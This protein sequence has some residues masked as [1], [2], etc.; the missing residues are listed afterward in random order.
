M[1]NTIDFAVAYFGVLRAG[2][3]AVPLNPAYTEDERGYALSDSGVSLLVDGPLP[4]GP[5]AA[6]PGGVAPEDVAV[7]LYTS[8]T[9]RASEGR[10]ADPRGAGRQPRQLDAIQPP[11]VAPDDVVLLAMPFFHAYGL[12]TGLGMVAHHAATGVLATGRAGGES[13]IAE[14]GV[15]VAVGVPRCTPPG[16]GSRRRATALRG[17]RTAVCGAAPLRPGRRR[18]VRRADRQEH[19]H[20]VRAD[21][22]RA[23]AHHHGGQRPGQ[24]WTRSAGRCPAS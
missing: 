19:P 17:L 6:I 12:N 22:D 21:R 13:P 4:D 23:G 16:P 9:Q 18:P 3:V 15:T 5:V 14:H 1:P 11:V 10:D 2:R 8:G 20:R 7:L 24:E